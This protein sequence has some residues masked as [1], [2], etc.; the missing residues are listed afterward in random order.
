MNTDRIFTIGL[1]VVC[2]FA[3][4][5]L[6]SCGGKK[7]EIPD[8]VMQMS[9]YGLPFD[10]VGTGT[11]PSRAVNKIEIAKVFNAT[12]VPT[13]VST[14]QGIEKTW[15][16]ICHSDK[17]YNMC[18]QPD[19]IL[20]TSVRTNKEVQS[21]PLTKIDFLA[22]KSF[23]DGFLTVIKEGD[24]LHLLYYKIVIP[25]GKTIPEQRVHKNTL[26]LSTLNLGDQNY[27][28]AV[29]DQ[30]SPGYAVWLVSITDEELDKPLYEIT[31]AGKP[32]KMAFVRELITQ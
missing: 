6:V 14:A 18:V 21:I 20:V 22:D 16:P 24:K 4:L 13:K 25:E 31:L 10:A 23:T 3:L 5:L 29:S 32:L 9:P 11:M 27:S 26:D 19:K 30:T 28:V 15:E 7:I 12:Y 17:N 1:T 8:E 2:V